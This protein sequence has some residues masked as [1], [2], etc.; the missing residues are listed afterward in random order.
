M[1]SPR[2]SDDPKPAFRRIVV[3][4]QVSCLAPFPPPLIPRLGNTA[5]RV[6]EVGR[7]HLRGERGSMSE[8]CR[9]PQA[10]YTPLHLAA[11]NGHS[12]VVAQLLAAGLV[13]DAKC[14]VR[15]AGDEECR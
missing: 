1:P 6:C 13:A 15:R 8:R 4:R 14:E 7:T 9:A 12:A 3:L 11:T 2:K 5:G 10:G